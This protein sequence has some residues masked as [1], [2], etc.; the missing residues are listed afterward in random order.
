MS[1]FPA[2]KATQLV[3]SYGES[4]ALGP[5]DLE[6]PAGQRVALVGANGSGKT[7][8]FRLASGLL[9]RSSGTCE[10]FGTPAGELDARAALSYIAD[11]PVLY[12]DLSVREH[13]AYLGPLYGVEEW[14]DKGEH[15]LD[16]LGIAHRGDDLPSTF[17]RGLRQKTSLL[18]GFLR[19]FAL[20]LI[21]EPFVGLDERGRTALLGLLDEA[22]ATGAALVVAS[23]QLE[24]VDAADRLVA[25]NDGQ[26]IYDGKPEDAEVHKLVGVE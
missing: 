14:H 26:L 11:D 17:S 24:M 12:D 22:H 8:L 7:T 21:D 23:H 5:L 25:L 19:P 2:F 10:V 18:L 15:L 16:I 6:I 9:E 13:I 20:L 4:V 1:E 3:K